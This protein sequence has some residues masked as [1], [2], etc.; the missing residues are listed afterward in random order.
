MLKEKEKAAIE[1][2]WNDYKFFEWLTFGKNAALDKEL[3]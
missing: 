2:K 1:E 3:M